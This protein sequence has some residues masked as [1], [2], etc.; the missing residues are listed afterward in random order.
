[1]K[2]LFPVLGLLFSTALMLTGLL[3]LDPFDRI[4]QVLDR[5]FGAAPAWTQVSELY[6]DPNT[7]EVTHG[8]DPLPGLSHLASYWQRQPGKKR[9]LFLGNS[10]MFAVS[11]APGE[12]P[13]TE[14]EKTYPDVLNARLVEDGKT[15]LVY[16]LSAG[17]LSYPEA[18]WYVTYFSLNPN[19][20][21]DYVFLQLNYQS[22]WTGGIREGMLSML[23]E[24]DFRTVIETMAHSGAA[25]SGAFDEALSSFGKSKAEAANATGASRKTVSYGDR[26]ENHYRSCLDNVKGFRKGPAIRESFVQMLYRERLYFFHLKPTTARSITG[27]RL[28]SSHSAVEELARFCKQNQILLVMFNAPVNP[29][30]HLYRTQQDRA[31]YHQ[32]IQGVATR[33]GVPLHDFEESVPGNYWGKLL[34]GPD[35]MHMGRRGHQL[36]ADEMM[37]ALDSASRSNLLAENK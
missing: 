36:V 30:V 29:G 24:P 7:Q 22:F 14:P 21:P 19:L 26:I 8:D 6:Q 3:V 32:F 9:V 37:V 27:T 1:M 17:A 16:R 10:Q 35:P 13:P 23:E 34:N 18:L 31:S 20:R 5:I 12:P 15:M 4:N 2:R 11:L 28:L 25:Y 33:Y